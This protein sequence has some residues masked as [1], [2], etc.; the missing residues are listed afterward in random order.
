MNATINERVSLREALSE[1]RESK[2]D[3]AI[4]KS[5]RGDC[6]AALA[7]TGYRAEVKA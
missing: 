3:E 6:F 5:V 2:G 4:S 1:L 7:M